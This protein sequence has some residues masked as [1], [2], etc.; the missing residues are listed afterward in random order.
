M[1]TSYRPVQGSRR[2]RAVA[3]LVSLAVVLTAAACKDTNAGAQ[4]TS[5]PATNSAS[6]TPASVASGPGVSAAGVSVADTLSDS[7]LM[8]RADIGRL[9]GRDS[10]PIWVVVISD[11]QC[12]YCKM[13]HDT[14][15]TSLVR[16]YV[17]TGKVRLAYLNLPL[18]QH[19]HA[20]AEAGA[21]LC[22][23]VQGKF[24]PYADGLFHQQDAVA[25]MGS[26]DGL[27]DSL[28]RAQSLEMTEFA[29]CRKSNAIRNLIDSDIRQAEGS[30]ARST[31]TILV[32]NFIIQGV[33][34]YKDFRK[35][36]DTALFVARNAA[37]AKR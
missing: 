27:L 26:V 11:F 13:W 22:A 10:A 17:N 9:S 7:A 1:N 18:G 30:G 31:P 19:P 33:T 8:V 32:G 12:P 3:M 15:Y 2:G 35:A 16:D 23:G 29:R 14:T 5:K 6:S 21:S 25:R 4:D 28:G 34:P 20:R 37:K 36:V 24:W